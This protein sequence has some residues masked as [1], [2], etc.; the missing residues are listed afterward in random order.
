MK[1]I[2]SMGGTG[3]RSGGTVGGSTE[4]E[5]PGADPVVAASGA[6]EPLQADAAAPAAPAASARNVRRE[7]GG[8]TPAR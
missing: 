6:G 3:G 1:G 7:R 2:P 5:G 4:N 8:V